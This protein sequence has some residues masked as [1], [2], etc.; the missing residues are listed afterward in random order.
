VVAEDEAGAPAQ[1]EAVDEVGAGGLL[2]V[3][4]VV[5]DQSR[6]DSGDRAGVAVAVGGADLGGLPGG[7]ACGVGGD[8][9]AGEGAVSDAAGVQGGDV[10]GRRR[11]QV[12]DPV[13]VGGG[14]AELEVG[15]QRACDV[16][17]DEVPQ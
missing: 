7:G 12:G 9:R 3:D 15:A 2:L 1:V 6:Q 17:G 8:G 13:A 5:V 11:D 14:R 16:F 4:A 10:D